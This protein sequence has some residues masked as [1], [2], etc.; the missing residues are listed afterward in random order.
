MRR[1][2]LFIAAM[3]V[4]PPYPSVIVVNNLEATDYALKTVPT[5]IPLLH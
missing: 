1:Q 3:D 2:L 4:L 5:D